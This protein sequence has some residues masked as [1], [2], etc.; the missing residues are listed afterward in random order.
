MVL[1][2]LSAEGWEGGE[3]EEGRGCHTFRRRKSSRAEQALHEAVGS[4]GASEGGAGG[5]VEGRGEEMEGGRRPAGQSQFL[6][7][8]LL[9]PLLFGPSILEPNLYLYTL[10]TQTSFHIS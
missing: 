2:T 3:R 5:C 1:G 9:Q 10:Y 7:L 8:R 4:E 6:H